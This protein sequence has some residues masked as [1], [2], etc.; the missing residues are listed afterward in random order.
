ML[1]Q[2]RLAKVMQSSTP[3]RVS[4][5]KLLH[6]VERGSRSLCSFLAIFK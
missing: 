3:T 4:S 6:L 5:S 1:R 2:G